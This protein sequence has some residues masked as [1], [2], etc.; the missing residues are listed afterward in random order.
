MSYQQQQTYYYEQT[1]Y[2]APPPPIAT[3]IYETKPLKDEQ[4]TLILSV[5]S[6]LF[7]G[8]GLHRF[9]LGLYCSALTQL[10]LGTIVYCFFG[11][12]YL[13]IPLFFIILLWN[14]ID[15]IRYRELTAMVNLNFG[16]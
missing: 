16:N 9:Y 11:W 7:G 12:I 2:Q 3:A 1:P 8:L 5:L 14:I 4:L 13:Y 15:I 10:L 6:L